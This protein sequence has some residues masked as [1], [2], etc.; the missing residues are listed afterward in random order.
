M[1]KHTFISTKTLKH[2]FTGD[3]MDP[4]IFKKFKMQYRMYEGYEILEMR[5]VHP[6][7]RMFIKCRVFVLNFGR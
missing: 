2:Q 1:H 3:I 6:L 7:H 5:F 4:C